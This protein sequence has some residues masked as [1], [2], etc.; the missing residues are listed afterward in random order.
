MGDTTTFHIQLLLKIIDIEQFPFIQM[1]IE[2]E[3]THEEYEELF[4]L[5]HDIER[6][7]EQQKEEGLLNF[8]SLLVHFAGMLHEKLEPTETIQALKREGY[9]PELMT[10]FMKVMDKEQTYFYK[11]GSM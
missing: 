4:H 2:K 7:Y 6:K 9:F 11:H 5:L 3:L 8:S 10:E 1:V